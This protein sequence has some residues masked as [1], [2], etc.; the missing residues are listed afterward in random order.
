[1]TTQARISANQNNAK[2]ST[3]PKSPEGK[4]RSRMNALKHGLRAE[5]IVLPTEDPAA[6]DDMLAEWIDEWK[7]PTGT[8][9]QL[10]ER[11]VAAAWRVNRCVRV[12]AAA[13]SGRA[14][15]ALN[16]WDNRRERAIDDI[17]A[18]LADDPAGAV[19]WLRWTRAGIL[20]MIALWEGV[21][22][23]LAKPGGWHDPLEHHERMLNLCGLSAESATELT[24]A[25]WRLV[26]ANR[27]DLARID[28]I[29]PHPPEAVEEVRD[30]LSS[31]ATSAAHEL[32]DLWNATASDN[33]ARL[34]A[35]D[36]AACAF[37]PE[38][39]K[40]QRYEGRLDRMFRANLTQL[41]AV[42]KT[43]IDLVADE[44]EIAAI[45]AKAEPVAAKK[46]KEKASSKAVAPN[47]P[48]AIEPEST[49]VQVER[50]RGGRIWPV[51]GVPEGPIDDD[52]V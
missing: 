18:G 42:T 30:R 1:M 52:R 4:E 17:A 36:L 37:T 34:D 38:D 50:D 35:A 25:S 13:F 28:L 6:F 40:L 44:V 43:G 32:S 27:P 47:E 15:E 39:E 26:L 46:V 2:L 51:E 41:M 12:E 20:R 22:D 23:A 5:T 8:R 10:V 11:T 7:P 24:D 3:G 19:E 21:R 33:P 49:A 9:R 31:M 45:E 48:T 14:L 16:D 29:P